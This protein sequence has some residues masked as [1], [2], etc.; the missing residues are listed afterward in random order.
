MVDCYMSLTASYT[1]ELARRIDR[2]VPFGVKWLEECMPPD[3]YDAYAEVR[4]KVGH[5]CM[6]TTGEHE[7]TRWGFKTLLDKKCCDVLQPDITWLGGLTEAR[8]V[9][10]LASAYDI[11]VIPHGSSVYSYHL[12]FAFVNCPVGELIILAPDADRI[13]PLFGSLF[14]D[15][16]LPVDGYITLADKPGFG[17]TLNPA[18]KLVRPYPRSVRTFEEIEAAKDAR[19]PDQAEWLKRAATTIPIG[20]I[21]AHVE[22]VAKARGGGA[23]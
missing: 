20:V 2:E 11:P 8:R 9:V 15:E 17:V 1:I 7:Y 4:E 22:A 10:A 21:P 13:W 6:F 18:V 5:L 23:A 12:Q 19:T 14:T 16:P 3:Q